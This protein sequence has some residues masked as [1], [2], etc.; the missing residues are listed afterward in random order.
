M[1]KGIILFLSLIIGQLVISQNLSKKDFI[2]FEWYSNN[3]DSLFFKSDTIRLIK[4]NNINKQI[5]GKEFTLYYESESFD[6]SESVKFQFKRNGKLLVWVRNYHI[7]SV[8]IIGER[9]WKINKEKTLLIIYKNKIKE[10]SFKLVKKTQIEFENKGQSFTTTE[11]I[12][13][14]MK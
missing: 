2:N 7:S 10:W 5:S 8:P 12:M 4:Y 1:K 14:K 9:K 3:N 13:N 11:L 6:D